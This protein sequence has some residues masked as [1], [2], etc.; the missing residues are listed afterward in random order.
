MNIVD[1]NG[2]TA[3]HHAAH[4]GDLASVN[5]LIGV[6]ADVNAVSNQ[7]KT[8]LHFAALNNRRDVV[9]SLIK[10]K[11]N[12]EPYDELH[13]TPL[14]LACRKGSDDCLQ[15]LLRK[16]ANI[17]AL[18]NRGWT[19]LHYASYNGHASAVNFLLKWEA[20]FDKLSSV[21][22]SQNRTAF[23]ISKDQKVKK[24]FNHIWQACKEG[25]L[26]MV[27]ILVREGESPTAKTQNLENTPMHIAAQH[28]HYLIVKFLLELKCNPNTLNGE[29]LT[30]RQ[31]I[32]KFW[33]FRNQ[34]KVEALAMKQKTKK[35]QDKVRELQKLLGDTYDLVAKNEPVEKSKPSTS[36]SSAQPASKAAEPSRPTSKYGAGASS[37]TAPAAS[38]YGATSSTTAARQ[39]TSAYGQSSSS[40]GQP[41]P[42]S[43]YGQRQGTSGTYGSRY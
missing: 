13:C 36:K 33:L 17:M 3:L 22:N 30:V 19:P 2:W 4:N 37:T 18:D 43:S 25:N 41:K 32:E 28:G 12:L 31:H 16:G 10:A 34:K 21:R 11:C 20:D 15:L 9:E 5:Q 1:A 29:G 7:F 23:I 14:H 42:A 35:E 8:P 39:P 26:D 38:K 27:R 24:G 6:K 40:Y